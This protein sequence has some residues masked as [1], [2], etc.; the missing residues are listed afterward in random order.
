MKYITNYNHQKQFQQALIG[1][2]AFLFL[3]PLF[4]QS[5]PV[6]ALPT[7]QPVQVAMN[8]CIMTVTT[9]TNSY[10]INIC[11]K[12]D[13]TIQMLLVNQK[14]G[15]KLT[16]PAIQVDT[17][18]N[19]FRASLTRREKITTNSP[20]FLIRIPIAAPQVTTYV[21]DVTKNQ[22]S[23]TKEIKLPGNNRKSVEVEKLGGV[24]MSS[25]QSYAIA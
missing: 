4:V 17:S 5:L 20:P 8:D 12:T 23:I 2:T 16:L 15:E 3:T 6:Q 22:F 10:S 7:S 14:T 11:Q 25:S 18:G 9:T 19:V 13:K 21:L 24:L 1:A